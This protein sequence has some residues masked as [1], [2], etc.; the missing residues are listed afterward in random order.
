MGICLSSAEIKEV[1]NKVKPSA[2]AKVLRHAGIEC[3]ARP[4]GTLI[5]LTEAIERRFK[6]NFKADKRP[7]MGMVR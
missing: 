6:T 4:D 7:Q 3:A 2:Q 5:V 1:T